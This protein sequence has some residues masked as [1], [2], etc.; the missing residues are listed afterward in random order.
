MRV[1]NLVIVLVLLLTACG[2]HL[3]GSVQGEAGGVGKLYLDNASNELIDQMNKSLKAGGSA[4]VGS[5]SQA[6][7]TIQIIDEYLQRRALSTSAR[8]KANEFELVYR[9][10]FELFGSGRK[11]LGL[12]EP[13]EIRRT[14]FNDQLDIIAKD[15]EEILIRTEMYQQAVRTFLDRIRLMHRDLAK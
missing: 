10:K 9:V 14:Y 7:T 5:P 12:Q 15:T 11:S 13:I 6:D 4:L 8:G 2:Y 3:R 1:K